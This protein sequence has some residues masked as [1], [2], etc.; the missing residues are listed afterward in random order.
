MFCSFLTNAVNLF[1][2]LS[3]L[4]VR[5]CQ[6]YSLSRALRGIFVRPGS[7]SYFS[8]QGSEKGGE[9]EPTHKRQHYSPADLRYILVW[10]E[11]WKTQHWGL[12]YFSSL[13][14]EPFVLEFRVVCWYSLQMRQPCFVS[15]VLVLKSPPPNWKHN[16]LSVGLWPSVLHIFQTVQ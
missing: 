4:S 7:F 5:D 3:I 2:Q 14:T 9:A 13:I 8:V 15:A 16:D 11:Y 1:K 10:M 6:C 12:D